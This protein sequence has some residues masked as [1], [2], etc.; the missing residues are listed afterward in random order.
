MWVDRNKE[1]HVGCRWTVVTSPLW[2]AVSLGTTK[3]ELV[4]KEIHYRLWLSWEVTERIQVSLFEC[5]HVS[6]YHSAHFSVCVCV[7][8]MRVCVCFVYLCV[9]RGELVNVRYIQLPFSV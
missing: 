2:K 3:A 5:R 7:C 8:V 1:H 9:G 6:K 4:R